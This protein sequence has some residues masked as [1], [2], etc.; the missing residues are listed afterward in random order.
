MDIVVAKFSGQ[1]VTLRSSRT[2]FADISTSE[3][4]S[5]CVRSVGHQA[6]VVAQRCSWVCRL[7]GSLDQQD[8]TNIGRNRTVSLASV[9]WSITGIT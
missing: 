2:V 8:V 7:S 6:Q 5:T 3:S 9:C 4:T 1:T